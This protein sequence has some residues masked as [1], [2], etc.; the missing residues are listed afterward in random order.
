MSAVGV[1]AQAASDLVDGHLLYRPCVV[2]HAPQAWGSPDGE[3]PSLAGQQKRYLEKQLG[4]FRSGARGD[5]AMEVVT[6]HPKTAD[7]ADF[8]ALAAYCLR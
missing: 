8:A 5:T 4:L 1:V 6:A 2:C 7:H 3:I